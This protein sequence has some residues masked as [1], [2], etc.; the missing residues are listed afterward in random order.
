MQMYS[1]WLGSYRWMRLGGGHRAAGD[2]EAA[3]QV[4]IQMSKGMGTAF[5]PRPPAPGDPV[6]GPPPGT[7]LAQPAGPGA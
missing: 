3:R 2:C 5:T 7:A 1:D 6:P 4:L